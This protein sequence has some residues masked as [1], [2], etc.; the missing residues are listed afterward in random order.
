MAI[1][2]NS[3]VLAIFFNVPQGLSQA[4]TSATVNGRKVSAVMDLCSTDSYLSEAVVQELKLKMHP[5]SKG[6]A[7]AQQ[8]LTT[9]YPGYVAVDLHLN[10]DNQSYPAT[11]LGLLCKLCSDLILGQNFH[12]QYLH[13]KFEYEGSLPKLIVNGDNTYCA[14]T[15]TTLEKP[16]LFPCCY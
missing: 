9:F 14:L 12:K 2:F 1:V 16:S 15:A 6:V 13:V 3:H 10:L 5:T 11:R 4:A 7:M 8:S